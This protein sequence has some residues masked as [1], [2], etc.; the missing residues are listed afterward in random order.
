[1]NPHKSVL[2]HLEPIG[3]NAFKELLQ[4][5]TPKIQFGS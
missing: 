2:C 5:K 4:A 1:M 3:G